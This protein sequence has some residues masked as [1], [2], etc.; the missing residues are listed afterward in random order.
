MRVWGI[1]TMDRRA[2]RDDRRG[3]N[4][5]TVVDARGPADIDALVDATPA[6]RDRVV[7]LVRAASIVVVVIW[8]WTLSVTHWHDGRLTMPNPIGH[9]SGLWLLTW[10]FQVM[11]LFFVVGGFSNLAGWTSL[12]ERGVHRPG[13]R[14][15]RSRANR[16]GRPAMAMVATWAVIDVILRLT[17][18]GTP[19]VVSWGLV[20]FVPLWFLAMYG[21]ATALVP[22][23]AELHRRA[24]ASTLAMLAAVIALGDVVRFGGGFGGAGYV[25]TAGVWIFAHQLGYFW[26]DGT[27]TSMRR[28][29]HVAIAL[30][31]LTG[32]VVSTNTGVY[33]RSTVAVDGEW[34]SNMFPTTA[35]IAMLAV[36]QLG[37]VLL[38]RPSLNAWLNRSRRAW[39]ATVGANGVAMTVF[40][41]HMTAVVAVIGV[42]HLAGLEL[43]DDP[44]LAWWV[45]RPLWLLAPVLVLAPIVRV[46]LPIE[47]RSRAL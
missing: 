3:M 39:R 41:W 7:D 35:P 33:P 27:L 25:S 24:P 30:V 23:T 38:L 12:R 32:L 34:L 37:L 8:H 46:F 1:V 16:L 4:S 20:V 45:Q 29:G 14:F 28:D 31:G 21:L 43:I 18:P 5:P 6:D 11:P 40:C 19:S 17:R 22:V 47:T 36:F 9:T 26:R 2:G 15:V 10:I 13:R 44:T 42:W